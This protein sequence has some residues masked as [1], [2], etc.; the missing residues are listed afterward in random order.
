MKRFLITF[1]LLLIFISS[2]LLFFQWLGFTTESAGEAG[3]VEVNQSYSIIH[4]DGRFN[5]TQTLRLEAPVTAPMT[6]RWPEGSEDFTCKDDK[7]KSC[8]TKEN[9]EFYV[10]STYPDL[11]EIT[12]TYSLKQS[13]E[14]E[15]V[16]LKNWYPVLSDISTV[17][18]DIQLTEK[19]L[20]N[21]KWIAGYQS[22]SHK[23]LDYIDYYFFSGHGEPSDLVWTKEAWKE[24]KSSAVRVLTEEGESAGFD[25]LGPF[26]SHT[27]FV[28][29]I[30]TKKIKPFQ[31][32]HLI[33][34]NDASGEQLK[35]IRQSLMYQTL[36]AK[37][38]D[39][40][41]KELVVGILFNEP[42]YNAKP[43]WIYQQLKEGLSPAEWEDLR[44]KVKGQPVD[45]VML[46]DAVSRVTGF[47]SS[48]FSE[49]LKGKEKPL[50]ILKANKPIMINR[51]PGQLSY[52]SFKQ[53]KFIQFPETVKALGLEVKELGPGVYFTAIN[54]N[55]LRFYVNEDYFIYNEENY[56]LLIKPVQTVGDTVYM[57]VDWFEKLFNVE[58]IEKEN[59]IEILKEM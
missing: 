44:Q 46:D 58:V 2:G 37:D 47:T 28:T 57:D 54:G 29:I 59:S 21:G 27:G 8:L 4:Q 23:K 1:G 18:T 7:E 49:R 30:L 9:G 55:T 12:I 48:F 13:T 24:K 11:R 25:K 33:V 10:N 42:P 39:G 52:I 31:S 35:G 17:N 34:M 15:T 16:L 6:I 41:L 56:G 36:S 53:K 43:A 14:A 20:R 3:G 19:S 38:E 22:S 51:K 32:P 45:R 50:L 40:W 26:E 5:V